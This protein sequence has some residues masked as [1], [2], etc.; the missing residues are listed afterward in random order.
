MG[1][2]EPLTTLE[3]PPAQGRPSLRPANILELMY[4]ATHVDCCSRRYRPTRYLLIPRKTSH[5]HLVRNET[6]TNTLRHEHNAD[7]ASEQRACW[8]RR[9]EYTL[10]AVA[11]LR[12]HCRL[13]TRTA[14]TETW[15]PRVVEAG[16]A[17]KLPVG[18][19]CTTNAVAHDASTSAHRRN[20]LMASQ[21]RSN[22]IN[23]STPPF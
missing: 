20:V 3:V 12:V 9:K 2:H 5:T 6:C 14:V 22:S 7:C 8:Y 16:T 19:T 10:L 15:W 23:T 11:H 17:V 4:E 1:K 18:G 13:A 21:T